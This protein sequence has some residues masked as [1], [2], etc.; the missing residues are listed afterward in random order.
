ME[1]YQIVYQ[2]VEKTYT[3]SPIP[4]AQWMWQNHLL[5][6]A[7]HAEKLA[8]K[9]NANLDLAVAGALLHDF[10]DAFVHRHSELHEKTSI[11]KSTDLLREASYSVEEIKEVLEQ[12]IAPHSCKNGFLPKTI[13]GQ[14]LAT[15]DAIAHLTTDF[16]LQFSWMHLP[17]NKT[18]EQFI[19]W[20]NEKINRDFNDKIFFE[21]VRNDL[22]GRFNSLKDIFKKTS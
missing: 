5:V 17:E 7:Q 14:V 20:V 11:E 16:Y 22:K 4:F 9:Y 12:V 2:L 13:E 19:D 3:N 18:Y 15:A 8:K 6:V 21:E 10:G 1:K